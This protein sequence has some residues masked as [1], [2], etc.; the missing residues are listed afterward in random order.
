MP[1]LIV[2]RMEARYAKV[3]DD[4]PDIAVEKTSDRTETQ[5]GDSYMYTIA[6]RNT[7]NVPVY[8]VRVFDLVPTDKIVV[9]DPGD[10]L[11][12]GNSLSWSVRLLGPSETTYF[13]YRVN[14]LESVNHGDVIHNTTVARADDVDDRLALHSVT[15]IQQMP[16][17]GIVAANGAAA[18]RTLFPMR[19]AS[20]SALPLSLW[21]TLLGMSVGA[22][23]NI[24]RRTLFI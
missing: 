17:T 10:A 15:V 20:H 14:V 2:Q 16:Q 24:L 9:T 19:T 21:L 13:R 6:V 22:G 8:N 4:P 7:T 23:G 11:V 18:L 1:T 3:P 12:S 5:R